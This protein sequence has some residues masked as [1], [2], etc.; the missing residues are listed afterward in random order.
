M[1]TNIVNN[2]NIMYSS[3]S[4]TSLYL[5]CPRKR[6]F[7]N[8]LLGTGIS[9]IETAVPLVTGGCVHSGIE[10][11][12]TQYVT[13]G[14]VN[15]EISVNVGKCYYLDELDKLV[16]GEEKFQVQ[17]QCA[18][19]EVLIRLWY[20]L[21][22]PKI[23]EHY[24]ILAIEQE[25]TFEIADN[26][27]YQSKPDLILIHKKTGDVV[28]Y[29]LKTCKKFDY[30]VESQYKI[31]LQNATEPYATNIWLEE[32]CIKIETARQM[33]AEVPAIPYLGKNLFAINNWL[34]SKSVPLKTSATRFCYLVKGERWEEHKGQGDYRTDNPFLYGY[35]KFNASEVEYRYSNKISK[36]ENKSGYGYLGKGWEQFPVWENIDIGGIKGWIEW[37]SMDNNGDKWNGEGNVFDDYVISLPDVYVNPTFIDRRIKEVT[38]IENRIHHALT[39]DAKKDL[40]LW[41]IEMMLDKVFNMNT[42]SCYYPSR[43]EF[44]PICPNGNNDYREHIA[45]DPLNPEWNLYKARSPHHKPEAEHFRILNNEKKSEI[46]TTDSTTINSNINFGSVY[47]SSNAD[48]ED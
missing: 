12:V 43:C 4:A 45:L 24:T 1:S 41:T 28:N 46:I 2:S 35:R 38:E 7:S 18:L 25:I 15:I 31:N 14:Q 5:E 23:Q 37:L 17:E 20:L 22:W 8:H 39:E 33:L 3:Q 36:P 10:D 21:E 29:S 42:Q 16:D 19:V 13:T 47:Y 9:A 11:I 34:N 30:R 32:L 6:Y 44:L 40:S 27:I 48:G 26:I